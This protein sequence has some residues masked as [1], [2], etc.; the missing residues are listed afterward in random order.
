VKILPPKGANEPLANE[1]VAHGL[2]AGKPMAKE[3]TAREPGG[4]ALLR[5][6]DAAPPAPPPLSRI[7]G[8]RD[9]VILVECTH[10]AVVLPSTGQRFAAASLLAKQ[11]PEHTIVA[12]VRTLIQKR[13]ATVRPGE[14]P[15]RPLLRFRVHPQG[16]GVYYLAY[17]LLERLQLPMSRENLDHDS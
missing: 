2:M 6:P 7:I 11:Q 3:P 8:S 13:Q 12:A 4:P 9:W 17:P 16:L 5:S 10:D 1:P 14:P 15:Y